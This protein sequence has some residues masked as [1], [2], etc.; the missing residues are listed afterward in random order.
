M[1]QPNKLKSICKKHIQNPDF[2]KPISEINQVKN[3][4]VIFKFKR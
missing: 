2:Q 4:T 1:I 3:Q